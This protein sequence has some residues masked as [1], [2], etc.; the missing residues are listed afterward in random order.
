MNEQTHISTHLPIQA[1]EQEHPALL[2]CW[3]EKVSPAAVENTI[4][5]IISFVYMHK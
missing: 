3:P 1:S 2:G 5:S 4:T